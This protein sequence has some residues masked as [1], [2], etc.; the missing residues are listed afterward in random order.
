MAAKTKAVLAEVATERKRQRQ[1]HGFDATYDDLS[2]GADRL[3][4]MAARYAQDGLTYRR[5]DRLVQAAALAVAAVEA[6]DRASPFR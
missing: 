1:D 5:R 3:A 2:G 6:M 4:A